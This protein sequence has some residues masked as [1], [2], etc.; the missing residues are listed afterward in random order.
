MDLFEVT[1]DL[2]N[3]IDGLARLVLEVVQ[4]EES[5]ENSNDENY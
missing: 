5:E 1:S 4:T 2:Q 3:I